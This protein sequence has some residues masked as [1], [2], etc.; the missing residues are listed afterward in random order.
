M[1]KPTMLFSRA[2]FSML[3]VSGS[4]TAVVAACGATTAPEP[5][6]GP[7][8]PGA[9]GSAGPSAA[10][11]APPEPLVVAWAATPP[12]QPVIDGELAEWG[13]VA[14]ASSLTLHV[15][16]EGAYLAASLSGVA[17]DGIW[18]ELST[19][20]DELPGLGIWQRDGQFV[21]YECHDSMSPEVAAACRETLARH[22]RMIAERKKGFTRLFRLDREGGVR[23]A[24]KSGLEAVPSAVAAFRV[25]GSRVTAEVKLPVAALP[26]MTEAPAYTFS[27]F[28]V[29]GPASQDPVIVAESRMDLSAPDGVAF[30]PFGELRTA[31]R[32]RV[33]ADGFSY[34][35]S[36]PNVVE[37]TGFPDREHGGEA[38]E[39][40]EHVLWEP[41]AKMGDVEV[42]HVQLGDRYLGILKGSAVVELVLQ[43][44]E[45]VGLVERDKAIHVFSFDAHPLDPTTATWAT[46]KVTA[47]DQEGGNAEPFDGE[48]LS[49]GW[50]SV[51]E[52]HTP[53][54]D[55]FGIRGVPWE[56]MAEPDAAPIELSWKYDAKAHR[57]VSTKRTLKSLPGKSKKP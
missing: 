21:K 44:G 33:I 23:W 53:T 49:A 30:E 5:A 52:F 4:L 15:T 3:A 45:H 40:K 41:L 57:Y 7:P 16:K 11:A 22:E 18:I 38:L 13:E 54:F 46:W 25:K 20:V 35:P 51:E 31:A 8:K 1:G 39:P 50:G 19:P 48:V 56:V 37:I 10:P 12:E 6:A 34:H 27:L 28:A 32:Q 42:G 43:E 36:R 26:R 2:V 17:R 47:V 9:S 14:E 29:P 24:G 55:K